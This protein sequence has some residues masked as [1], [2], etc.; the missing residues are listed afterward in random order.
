MSTPPLPET[1]APQTFSGSTHLH[2]T[3]HR[4]NRRHA[5][6]WH[7]D[8]LL[9]E[10]PCQGIIHEAS[11]SGVTLFL[12]LNPQ[13]LKTLWL[14]MHVP[15]LDDQHQQ[16]LIEVEGKIVYSL[17]DNDMQMFRCGVQFAQFIQ[18]DDRT[19]LSSRLA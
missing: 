19:F 12:E 1:E 17:H 8:V 11:E 10:I 14:R 2:G 16:R 7:A 6:I 9:G 18:N 5:V 13:K 4:D 3:E 15:P